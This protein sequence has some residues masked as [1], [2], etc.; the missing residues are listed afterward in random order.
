MCAFTSFSGE[1]MKWLVLGYLL[2]V[3]V[4]CANAEHGPLYMVATP[5]VMRVETEEVVT[6]TTFGAEG[7][8]HFRL[9]LEDYPERKR[10]L[11]ERTLVVGRDDI[12]NVTM[13]LTTEDLAG[14]SSV[15]PQ[16]SYVYLVCQTVNFTEPG[17]TET[18]LPLSLNPGFIFIQ[19]DKPVY[20]PDQTVFMRVV[21][22]NE[23]FKP[24]NWPLQI[25]VLNPK[26]LAISRQKNDGS[27]VIFRDSLRIPDNPVYGN[28]TVKVTFANGLA[29]SSSVRFEV[30]EYVLPTFGV[31][32]YTE[33]KQKVLLPNETH[34][35]SSVS[36][37]YVFGK[38]VMGHVTVVFGLIWHGHV[39]TLGKKRNMELNETGQTDFSI[40]VSELRLPIESV[41]FP[42]GG[43]LHMEAIVTEY[44]SGKVGRARDSSV[45]FAESLYT[46]KFTRSSRHFKPG[47]TYSL[48]IDTIRA[49]GEAGS[50]LSL[51]VECS[52]QIHDIMVPLPPLT[53]PGGGDEHRTDDRGHL[54]VTYLLASDVRRL[55]FK[56]KTI[57]EGGG[58]EEGAV[59]N[60]GAVPFNSPSG[61]FL[62]VEA[63]ATSPQQRGLP[64]EVG[65]YI[66]VT[67]HY[68]SS[69]LLTHVNLMVLSR[70]HIV[71]QT[72]THNLGSNSTNFYFPLTRQMLPGVRIVAFSIRGHGRE[73]E[74]ISDSVWVDM[75]PT[76]YGEIK[77]DL[78]EDNPPQ[79]RPRDIGSVSITGLPDMHVGLLAV[80]QAVYLLN[81]K[82][83]TRRSVFES[84]LSHD[85]GCG[86]GRGDS[87]AA[88][89][90]S[91]GLTI[92]SNTGLSTLPRSTGNC[93]AK[94]VR[95]R[96]ATAMEDVC[97]LEG[98]RMKLKTQQLC[99]K[100]AKEVKRLTGLSACAQHFFHCCSDQNRTRLYMNSSGRMQNMQDGEEG[101][102]DVTLDD[103][104]MHPIGD[105][106]VPVRSSFPESWWFDDFTIGPT[107]K[108]DVD[109]AL[110]DSI[111]TWVLQAVGV[112]REEGLC[113]APPLNVT[114]FRPFFVHMDLPYTAVRL[115]QLEVRAT[116]YNYMQ[117]ALSVRLF[118]QSVE[119]VCYSGT[120]GKNSDAFVVEVAPNDAT[121][122]Y[123]PIVPL[124]MGKFPVRVFAISAWGRD[125]VEKILRV[126]GEG[127][128]KVHTVSVLL[129][130]S[131]KRF[132]RD[133]GG[134]QTF[135]LTNKVV[136][137]EQK[138]EVQLDLD[139]P[140]EVIP[141]TES[142]T[143]SAMG[144]LL[145]PTV[146]GIVDGVE[147][148]L[149]LPTGCGEQNLIYLGPNVYTMRYLKAVGRLS[150]A[151]E[152]KARAFV[153]QGLMRQMTF[154]KDDGSFGTWPHADSSTW[155][156]AFAM[157]VLCQTNNFVP[158]DMNATCD[159][160]HWLRTR[161]RTDGS[162]IE[163]VWVTHREMLGGVNGDMSV[164][165]FVLITLLECPCLQETRTEMIDKAARYLEHRLEERQR[166]LTAA[167][168][169][170]ALALAG[171]EWSREFNMKLMDHVKTDSQ[172]L[173]YWDHAEEEAFGEHDKPYWYTKKPGALA[174]E[175]TAYA[176]LT[177]LTLNDVTASN[178]IVAW[179]LQQR[180]EHGSFVSTQD[181]VIALQAL[182]EYSIKSFS[183]ILDMT[184]H[185]R[186][187]V[188]EQ[189]QKTF[190]LTREDALVL[191]S[192]PKVPTGGKLLFEASGTG[193]GVMHVDV[194]FNV[195]HDDNVCRFDLTVSSLRLSHLLQRFFWRPQHH[196][197]CE[198]C[199]LDCEEEEAEE[200]EEED[201]ENFTFPS[202]I[203]RIREKLGLEDRKKKK[204]PRQRTS[205]PGSRVGRPFSRIGRRPRR[206]TL[207]AS[208]ARVVCVEVCT[209]YRGGRETGMS[210]MDVGLFTGYRPV[211][212]D[213]QLLKDKRRVDH[214]EMSQR[215]V[216]FYIDEISHK[217]RQCIKF[218][219]KQVHVV[220]NLQPARVQ[221]YD[222]YNPEERCTVF[223]KPDNVSGQLANFC[224]DQK[225]ICQCL[226]G[227]CGNCEESWLQR[228][229]MDLY[230][231][232]C[233]NTS[234]AVVVRILDRDLEKVGFE[235]LLG[236]VQ[237]TVH[238]PGKQQLNEGDK[239]ILLKRDS[240]LCPRVK[241]GS[242]YLLLLPQPKRFKDVEGNH[243]YV[244]LLDKRA[245]VAEYQD[246]K[247]RGLTKPQRR[248][249]RKLARVVKRLSRRRCRRGGKKKA[250]ALGGR[251]RRK[252]RANRKS[253]LA[254]ARQRRRR[255]RN[256]LA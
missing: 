186:S 52:A 167:I 222:Y 98:A 30:R 43:K 56:V 107:G 149:R 83:L 70:G 102:F 55:H 38:P 140:S 203:P 131:G 4:L 215:S 185:V 66:T 129:D 24:T 100:A 94:A 69:Q 26:G 157:K 59:F 155:L 132:I 92:L 41:W 31:E 166:P 230:R 116:V 97:C 204:D 238:Q 161:Q 148:L 178:P 111:T 191:K 202:I 248:Q 118:L 124:E 162:F 29:T 232:A 138:Q 145:G 8:A 159:T 245:V 146:R 194:R 229:W 60:F 120:S 180:E 40:P 71:W 150:S 58:A 33:A 1:T 110:P 169:A 188:D 168:T 225:R 255:Q 53:S 135:S 152:K 61:T 9:Y 25:D 127:L 125:A 39:F 244:F 195:P 78:T 105:E 179:L 77:L 256:G 23:D 101:L 133:R 249:A 172:G 3:L 128:E 240:C 99:H 96:R 42:N 251:G 51:L 183:A 72:R 34:F 170:Y 49:N 17:S 233:H 163:D 213:L 91:S 130:P 176:L 86:D 16:P 93:G 160:L 217:K 223:Y 154:R 88:V 18:I 6:V 243:V 20:T 153:R 114:A 173:K 247:T 36:A 73:A 165:A 82:A 7:E 231:W 113:V 241:V 175:T 189:F 224:D 141:D 90:T 28:W 22:L 246:P 74:V 228:G 181:T 137:E 144:D 250:R 253:R 119:G 57:G 79:F 205:H 75:K 21:A 187:E 156:T 143:V 192:V 13:K 62:Q 182:S 85:L 84:L 174:V 80:D 200:E 63:E 196:Q 254:R 242:S 193:I 252:A 11:S 208:S 209:R 220:K 19:T 190:S 46:I 117:R 81:Q 134:N 109:F 108:M 235:R 211:D 45:V 227:R 2:L 139:L 236:V 142:C 239:L 44:A 184:C 201:I 89:F 112:S 47:L 64:L 177:Q 198:P 121:S 32:F 164:T 218:R 35:T 67:T 197:R 171:S 104:V 5:N 207:I 219:A 27:D 48:K 54:T 123:F 76:C 158:V 122:V 237:S 12:G 151:I 216:I 14:L 50:G 126:E 212:S 234:N 214:Y 147:E 65:D 199:S 15:T 206:S 95:K 68:T 103:D 37:R 210:V 10:R 87:S 136:A 106:N 226:E 221:V 115:E